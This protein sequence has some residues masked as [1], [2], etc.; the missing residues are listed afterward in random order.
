MPAVVQLLNLPESR[1]FARERFILFFDMMLAVNTFI[2]IEDIP[3]IVERALKEGNPLYPV[4]KIM[5][6][7]DCEKVVRQLMA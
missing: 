1:S 3:T 2:T 6:P 4:P 5:S 7:E